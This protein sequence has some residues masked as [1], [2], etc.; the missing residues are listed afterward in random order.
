MKDDEPCVELNEIIYR[1]S[2]E[3]WNE[4]YQKLLCKQNEYKVA[5]NISAVQAI[6]IF[7]KEIKI[8]ANENGLKCASFSHNDHLYISLTP[9]PIYI[10]ID[11]DTGDFSVSA[12]HISTKQFTRVKYI[13]GLKWIRDYLAVDVKPLCN[14]VSLAREKFY[15]SSKGA[16]IAKTSIRALCDSILGKGSIPY[17]INQTRLMSSIIIHPDQKDNYEI[18]IYH[19]A[20]SQDTSL[21]TRFLKNPHEETIEDKASCKGKRFQILHR[22]FLAD[23]NVL[24]SQLK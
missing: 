8:I 12:P 10:G 21:L 15:L 20:F 5:S 22:D 17:E 13:G 1:I 16:E 24:I 3:F 2:G 23:P 9:Y 18:Q 4:V 19:K 7:R 14:K 6:S 11:K